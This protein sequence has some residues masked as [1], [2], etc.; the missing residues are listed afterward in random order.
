MSDDT[1]FRKMACDLIDKEI[2]AQR[3]RATSCLQ[4]DK[5]LRVNLL[6][7]QY[8]EWK[9]DN[10]YKTK[11]KSL[12]KLVKEIVEAEKKLARFIGEYTLATEEAMVE[13]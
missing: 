6:E 8:N 12:E 10:F 11:P 7:E 13:N 5:V 3:W 2:Y 4:Y 9:D 1:S